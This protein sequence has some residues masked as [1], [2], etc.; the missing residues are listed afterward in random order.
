MIRPRKGEQ[1]SDDHVTFELDFLGKYEVSQSA[2]FH[3]TE[4]HKNNII[5]FVLPDFVEKHYYV[6]V[7]F[8]PICLGLFRY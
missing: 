2:L 1:T 7:F 8:S 3:T 6:S 5:L 4:D